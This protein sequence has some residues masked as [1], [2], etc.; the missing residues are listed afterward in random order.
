MGL[1]S[2]IQPIYESEKVHTLS[3]SN[4]TVHAARV[5]RVQIISLAK[6]PC[7]GRGLLISPHGNMICP[8]NRTI[9]D[10]PYAEIYGP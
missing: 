4:L 5:I 3:R 1:H 10:G 2:E 7:G 8:Q 9:S 6:C